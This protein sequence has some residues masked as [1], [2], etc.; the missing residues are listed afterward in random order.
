MS[1]EGGGYRWDYFPS[2][3][4]LCVVK[5]V[6]GQMGWVPASLGRPHI[7]GEGLKKF[8]QG[9]VGQVVVAHLGS[10]RGAWVASGAGGLSRRVMGGYAA[11]LFAGAKWVGCRRWEGCP[12]L[13]EPILLVIG[14]MEYDRVAR[15]NIGCM[16]ICRRLVQR[17][18]LQGKMLG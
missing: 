15:G 14:Q 13:D 4:V 18:L 5:Y 16:A 17:G 8:S 10:G 9:V 3:V 7:M 2:A 11:W 6:W 12:G 1:D